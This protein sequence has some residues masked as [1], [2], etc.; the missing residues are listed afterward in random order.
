MI[1]HIPLPVHFGGVL[2]G[3]G[4]SRSFFYSKE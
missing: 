1:Q 4:V 3:E 2:G